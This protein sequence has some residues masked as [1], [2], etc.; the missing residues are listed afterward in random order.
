MDEEGDA[1]TFLAGNPKLKWPLGTQSLWRRHV[2]VSAHWIT[3]VC[4]Y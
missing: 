3:G 1:V 4:K 2:I